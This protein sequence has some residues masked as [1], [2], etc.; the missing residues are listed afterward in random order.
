MLL[1]LGLM[2]CWH[3][4][5]GASCAW[6]TGKERRSSLAKAESIMRNR[7]HRKRRCK[8]IDVFRH[9]AWTNKLGNSVLVLD[10]EENSEMLSDGT[11]LT[12]D[13]KWSLGCMKSALQKR[14]EISTNPWT[15]KTSA[16][17]TI[18]PSS[19]A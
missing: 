14:H 6:V 13:V 10:V 12:S 8:R 4:F 15:L 1:E 17:Y 7:Q 18:S 5:D 19:S 3:E 11:W 9:L 2:M 16:E